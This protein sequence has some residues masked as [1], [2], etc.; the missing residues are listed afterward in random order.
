MAYHTNLRRAWSDWRRAACIARGY[1][2]QTGWKHRVRKA[3]HASPMWIVERTDKPAIRT[4][5]KEKR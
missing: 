5:W 2:Y 3:H 4:W 1:G